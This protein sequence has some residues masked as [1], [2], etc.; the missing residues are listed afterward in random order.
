MHVAIA[1]SEPHT[2]FISA[3]NAQALSAAQAHSTRNADAFSE[4]FYANSAFVAINNNDEELTIT[5]SA[6]SLQQ[7][8]ALMLQDEWL[9][10]TCNNCSVELLSCFTTATITCDA[11]GATNTLK[12]ALTQVRSTIKNSYCNA[13]SER[14]ITVVNM[15]HKRKVLGTQHVVFV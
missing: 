12:S 11:C 5:R 3:S 13:D 1:H 9:Y 10:A 8:Y 14:A 15:L 7:L 4:T 6:N 2:L